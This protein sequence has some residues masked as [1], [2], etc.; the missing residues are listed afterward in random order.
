MRQ[1]PSLKQRTSPSCSSFRREDFQQLGSTDEERQRQ[2]KIVTR[3]A[4]GKLE[5]SLKSERLAWA[6]AVHLNTANPHVHIAIQKQYLTKDLQ[7]RSLNKRNMTM[8]SST[9]EMVHKKT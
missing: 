3:F 4:I 2:V 6:G 7:G 8:T 9:I 1:R 5:K